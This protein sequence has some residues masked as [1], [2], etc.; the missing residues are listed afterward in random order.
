M[1]YHISNGCNMNDLSKL[2]GK[3]VLNAG[4]VSLLITVALF[5]YLST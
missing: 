4:F 2:H 5:Y 1:D 3:T